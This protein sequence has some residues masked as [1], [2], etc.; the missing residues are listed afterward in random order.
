[1]VPIQPSPSGHRALR[2]GRSSQQGQAYLLTT[3]TLSR[4]PLFS[5]WQLASIVSATLHETRLWRD[6]RLL[7]WVLMP[8][9]LHA[10]VSLGNEP[11]P[12]LLR[13]VKAVTSKTANAVLPSPHR[14]V[15]APAYHDRALRE[16][17]DLVSMARY[18]VLNPVRAGLVK[19]A[20]DYPFW[21][22]VWV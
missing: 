20:G 19:R 21:D 12:A 17:E 11:L 13:R 16:E 9:H 10:L 2:R 15:W 14:Q 1:M 4:R 3:A 7:C 8:D 18:I 6:A 5:D 22:A